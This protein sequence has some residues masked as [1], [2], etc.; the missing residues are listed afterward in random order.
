MPPT[1]PYS[2]HQGYLPLGAD[3]LNGTMSIAMAKRVCDSL[4]DCQ[5]FT[6]S[7]ID[8]PE[9]AGQQLTVWLK[10]SN[11]WVEH[12]SHLTYLKQRPPCEDA[13]F[14]R[15][16]K[17]GAG[18]YCCDGAGCLD[19][20]EYAAGELHCNFPAATP[21]GVP[22][23]AALRGRPLANLARAVTPAASAL[24]SEYEFS[25]N[26]G[27]AAGHDGEAD[28]LVHTRCDEPSP[29]WRLQLG[30][31]SMVAQLALYN[32]KSYRYRLVGAKI[33]LLAANKSVVTEV[34]VASAREAYVWTL[35]PPARAV[36]SIE[37]RLDGRTDCLHFAELEVF[38]ALE[39]QV[40]GGEADAAAPAAAAVAPA[41][42]AAAPAALSLIHI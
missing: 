35:T 42:A 36:S 1:V 13:R 2:S 37:L 20:R 29:W 6:L 10:A 11:E 33:R 25:E 8:E 9:K 26:G 31:P 39:A 18:P 3:L 19:A 40:D 27:A 14:K 41:A 30:G 23:C 12:A 32:R 21:H 17:A 24:S 15:F 38:G 5:G 7:A 28:S 22:R 34:T 4:A 16:A